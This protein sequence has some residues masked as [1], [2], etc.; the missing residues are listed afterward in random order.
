MEPCP[1]FRLQAL[2]LRKLH[3]NVARF[4][5]FNKYAYEKFITGFCHNLKNSLQI[6]MIW[7]F[8]DN[9]FII[10]VCKFLIRALSTFQTDL[11]LADAWG[12]KGRFP[13]ISL[14]GE[15]LGDSQ[16][17]IDFLKK[18]GLNLLIKPFRME[19]SHRMLSDH[20]FN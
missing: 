7:I 11:T 18:L 5:K 17:I 14:N 15:H 9:F 10:Y 8:H 1:H 16:L 19:V 4:T 3:E 6:Y 20:K 12:P 13:W 2:Y